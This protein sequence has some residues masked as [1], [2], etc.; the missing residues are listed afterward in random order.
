MK[1][2]ALTLERDKARLEFDD[3][4]TIT[5][6]QKALKARGIDLNRWFTQFE[7]VFN[8]AMKR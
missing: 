7:V 4:T 6:D 5:L 2:K 1:I 8:K 3:G